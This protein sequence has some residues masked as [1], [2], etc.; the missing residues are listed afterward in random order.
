MTSSLKDVAR[1]AGVAVGTVSRYINEPH[2]LRESTR[3]KIEP[4]IVALGYSPHSVA[5]SLRRG[6][7]GLVLVS[8]SALGNPYFADVIRGVDRIAQRHGFVTFVKEVPPGPWSPALIRDM[9]LSRA[10]DGVIVLGSDSPFEP[11]SGST[12]DIRHPPVVVGSELVSLAMRKLPSV[13]IDNVAAASEITQFLI[14][15]GHRRIAFMTGAQGSHVMDD[16]EIGFRNALEAAGIAICEDWLAYG[17]LMIAGGRRAARQLMERRDPPTAIVC[18]NDEMAIGAIAELRAMRLRVPD[19]VSIVGFDD[20]RYAEAMEP[21]LTTI[22]QA[23]ELLGER[24]FLRLLHLID[25]PG[26]ETGVEII[27]HRLV[28]RSSAAAPSR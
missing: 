28:V 11:E 20:I 10:A 8:V 5:R 27:P 19:D 12:P 9:I 25:D 14:D 26:S 1:M 15:L 18:G 13:R 16:R 7:T 4:A 22:A 24:C 6:R 21:P 2:R 23:R 3:R 17:D